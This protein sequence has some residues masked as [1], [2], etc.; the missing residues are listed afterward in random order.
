MSSPSGFGYYHVPTLGDAVLDFTGAHL[1]AWVALFLFAGLVA[2]AAVSVTP[3][4]IAVAVLCFALL[5]GA[6]A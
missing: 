3:M 6:W 2:L 5:A 4:A 1:I